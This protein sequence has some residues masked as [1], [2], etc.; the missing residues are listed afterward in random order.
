MLWSRQTTPGDAWTSGCSA[1]SRN[2]SCPKEEGPDFDFG[3][4][5]ILVKTAQGRDVVLAGQ[6][7]GVV[8]ALDPDKK[9]EIVW[10]ARVGKGGTIGGVQWGMS[11][12]GQNRL[13]CRFRRRIHHELERARSESGRR[14]DGVAHRRWQQ[15][16]AQR[17]AA[18]RRSRQLQ[19]RAIGCLDGDSRRGFLAFDGRPSA[20]VFDRGGQHPVGFRHGARL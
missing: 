2:A 7:S 16:L 8:Y 13:R 17:S 6:K 3:S 10:Q 11:S 20:R 12:D 15:D 18:V 1:D 14:T 19:P 9:G 4:S 5:A